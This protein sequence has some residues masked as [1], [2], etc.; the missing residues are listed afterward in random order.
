MN[1]ASREG[2]V[3]L[4]EGSGVWSLRGVGGW[5]NGVGEVD[6]ETPSLACR[7]LEAANAPRHLTSLQCSRSKAQT[8]PHFSNV[9]KAKVLVYIRGVLLVLL[10]T[11]SC[12]W[13]FDLFLHCVRRSSHQ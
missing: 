11:F 5:W 3:S 9:S 4:V 6:A 2:A 7:E 1:V 10:L 8:S 12:I 13:T